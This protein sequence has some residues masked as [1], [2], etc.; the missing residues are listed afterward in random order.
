MTVQFNQNGYIGSSMSVRA[1][2][3]YNQGEM[4]K[5]K[6]T[7]SAMLEAIAYAIQENDFEITDEQWV[8]IQKLNK[9]S[10]FNNFFEWSSWHHTSKYANET[11]FYSVNEGALDDVV[12]ENKQC[13]ISYEV[14]VTLGNHNLNRF[15][16]TEKKRAAW[17][18]VN[19]FDSA[20]RVQLRGSVEINLF[21]VL[22]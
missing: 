16:D 15:F 18:K 9:E 5:S 21:D 7:K 22:Y 19:G 4:P 1:I 10:I 6:W 3:A 14:R 2:E 17:L 12:E 11:D 20:K 8:N 13:K